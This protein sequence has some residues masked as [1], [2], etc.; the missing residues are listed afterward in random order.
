LR[1]SECNAHTEV[2]DTRVR[3]HVVIRVRL[4]FNMHKF[5]TKEE[6]IREQVTKR[7]RKTNNERSA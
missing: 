5:K 6:M 7:P 3:G 4:C 2:V 1:C